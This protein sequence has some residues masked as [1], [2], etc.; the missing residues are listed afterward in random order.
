MSPPLVL[1]GR[2]PQQYGHDVIDSARGHHAI[3]YACCCCLPP[4]VM[5][6]SLMCHGCGHHM[7]LD[8]SLLF[9]L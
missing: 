2:N 3:A 4:V 7:S 9:C 5:T 8:M 6:L 1:V